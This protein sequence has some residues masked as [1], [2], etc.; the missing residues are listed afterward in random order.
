MDDVGDVGDVLE[1]FLD[2]VDVGHDHTA[3]AVPLEAELVHRITVASGQVSR[4]GL[5]G[6]YP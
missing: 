6:E 1:Q 4:L 3:A 2:Q 5:R